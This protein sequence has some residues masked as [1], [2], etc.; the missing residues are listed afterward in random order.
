MDFSIY[1]NDCQVYFE[2]LLVNK[3]CVK[4]ILEVLQFA[5]LNVDFVSLIHEP[6]LTFPSDIATDH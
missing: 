1:I 5:I 3:A 6:R 4:I 2:H